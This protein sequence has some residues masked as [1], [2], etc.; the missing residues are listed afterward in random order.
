LDGGDL[1]LQL[2]WLA[3]LANVPA[4]QGDPT[5]KNDQVSLMNSRWTRTSMDLI[6]VREKRE[7][8]GV[9]EWNKDDAV[10][11]VC[12]EGSYECGFLS[13]AVAGCRD[14]HSCAFSR[15][16]AACPELAR[17]VPECLK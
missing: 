7:R 3:V 17:R 8:V 13:A 2:G 16:L 15:E 12:R 11:C 9:S 4:P 5:R 14:E 1:E 10:A 6:Q